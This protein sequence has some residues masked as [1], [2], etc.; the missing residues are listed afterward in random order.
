MKRMISMITGVGPTRRWAHVA[1]P[2]V[3]LV[4]AALFLA[5]QSPTKLASQKAAVRAA[6]DVV[7][8]ADVKSDGMSK[9]EARAA[10]AKLPMSFEPNLGQT[11]PRVK[12]L[13]R[14]SGYMAFLTDDG[15][16]VRL[17]QSESESAVVTM[18]FSGGHQ[19]RSITP[20]QRQEGV[21]NYAVG[22]RSKW[23]SGVPN[24]SRVNYREV[25][26]GVDTVF[27][28]DG[29]R[30]RYDLVVH[31]GADPKQIALTF[32]GAKAMNVDDRGNL[33]LKTGGGDVVYDKPFVY[34]EIAG[35]RRPVEG[36]YRLLDDHQVGFDLG[37]YDPGQ[38]LVI[39]PVL[40]FTNTYVGG[41]NA[42][43]G[44][45]FDIVNGVVVDLSFVYITGATASTDF[46]CT[47]AA[48]ACASAAPGVSGPFGPKLAV[49]NTDAFVLVLPRA[50]GSGVKKYFTL[51]G[52]SEVDAGNGI[53]VANPKALIAAPQAVTVVGTSNSTDLPVTTGSGIGT[54]LGGKDAFV[55]QFTGAG[56]VGWAEFVGGP[57]TDSGLGIAFGGGN[58][59]ITGSTTSV[60]FTGAPAGGFQTT[61]Q[62][63]QDAYV[64]ELKGADGTFLAFTYY[65]GA[66]VENGNAIAWDGVNAR[67]VFDGDTTSIEAQ[68]GIPLFVAFPLVP[69]VAGQPE[70]FQDQNNA[71]VKNLATGISTTSSAFLAALTPSLALPVYS[72]FIGGSITSGGVLPISGIPGDTATGVAVDSLGN[73]YLVGN[74]TNTDL[75]FPPPPAPPPY[76][77]FGGGAVV[78]GFTYKLRSSVLA[79]PEVPGGA[80]ACDPTVTVAIVPAL[81]GYGSYTGPPSNAN[82]VAVDSGGQAYIVGEAIASGSGFLER[83]DPTGA[84]LN[85]LS[86]PNG[87]L[88]G[89]V[90]NMDSVA[91]DANR[92]MFVGGSF[93]DVGTLQC[94]LAIGPAGTPSCVPSATAFRTMKPGPGAN[95]NDGIVIGYSFEDIV[96]TPAIPNPIVIAGGGAAVTLPE[97]ATITNA[98]AAPPFTIDGSA[99]P[100]FTGV[101]YGG[102]SSGAACAGWLDASTF[103]A[104]TGAIQLIVDPSKLVAGSTG[105]PCGAAIGLTATFFVSA[106]PL[107]PLAG[108][109]NAPLAVTVILNVGGS[110]IVTPIPITPAPPGGAGVVGQRFFLEGTNFVT[111]D[112]PFGAPASG[113]ALDAVTTDKFNINSTPSSQPYTATIGP[114][115]GADPFPFG[116]GCPVGDPNT[117]AGSWLTW[118][119]S[120]STASAGTNF[121][122]TYNPAVLGMIDLANVNLF[123]GPGG[124][125]TCIAT[126]QIAV[127]GGGTTN[128]VVQVLFTSRL[129]TTPAGTPNPIFPP[130]LGTPGLTYNFPNNSFGQAV[131][132]NIL[133][134][135]DHFPLNFLPIISTQLPVACVFGITISPAFVTAPEFPATTPFNVNVDPTGCPTGN[136]TGVVELFPTFPVQ[137]SPIFVP[138]YVNV[139]NLGVAVPNFV[140]FGN[141]IV[142]DNNCTYTPPT[143]LPVVGTCTPAPPPAQPVNVADI[144]GGGNQFTYSVSVMTA[145]NVLASYPGTPFQAAG[146]E[147][148]WAKATIPAGGTPSSFTLSIN[149]TP[150]GFPGGL[151]GNVPGIYYQG[152]AAITRTG[153][154][155]ISNSPI[156]VAFAFTRYTQ[157]V[158]I[159]GPG[160]NPDGQPDNL[161]PEAPNGTGIGFTFAATQGAGLLTPQTFT[162]ALDGNWFANA[163]PPPATTPVYNPNGSLA[164]PPPFDGNLTID[165]ETDQGPPA[166]PP[167]AQYPGCSYT[168]D[169]PGGVFAGGQPALLPLV[170]PPFFIGGAGPD[171]KCPAGTN[172]WL[173]A[174]FVTPA[175]LIP[176]AA[177]P[178]EPQLYLGPGLGITSDPVTVSADV[179]NLAAGLYPARIRIR[180]GVQRTNLP[181][182]ID[183]LSVANGTAAAD[184]SFQGEMTIPVLLTVTGIN[185]GAVLHSSSP[186]LN[187]AF[188]TGGSEPACQAVTVTATNP[189][190][191]VSLPVNATLTTTPPAQTWLTFNQAGGPTQLAGTTTVQFSVCATATLAPATYNGNLALTS[192]NV[193]TVNVPV[194]FVVNPQPTI[195]VL[196]P[197]PPVT[198][199]T[200]V[201]GAPIPNQTLAVTSTPTGVSSLVASKTGAQCGFLTATLTGTTAPT[202]LTLAAS[203]T[204]LTGAAGGTVYTCTVNLNGSGGSP[205]APAVQ[206]S[207]PVT[208]TVYPQPQ[209]ATNLPSPPGI[210]FGF[211]TGNPTP[212][213]QIANLTV[214]NLDVF[215]G[216][217][218]VASAASTVAAQNYAGT[219][220]QPSGSQTG[221]LQTSPCVPPNTPC[222]VTISLNPAVLGL[223]AAGTYTGT[224]TYT[225]PNAISATTLVTL[226]VTGGAN[227]V[228]A[229][230]TLNFTFTYG[231]PNPANQTDGITTNP[232]PVP[233]AVVVPATPACA[234]LTT[235][236]L[237]SPNS[238]STLTVGVT[239]PTPMPAGLPNT[240]TCI[241]SVVNPPM[242]PANITVNLQLLPQPVIGAVPNPV[243]FL[244]FTGE[245]CPAP[246][247]IAVTVATPLSGGSITITPSAGTIT[248]SGSSFSAAIQPG[249][250]SA[251]ATIVVTVCQGTLAPGPYAGSV[252]ISSPDAADVTVPVN[253]TVLAV[254]I[255]NLSTTGPLVFNYTV[256]GVV[257]IAQD[258]NVT[259]LSPSSGLSIANAP[260]STSPVGAWLTTTPVAATN[261]P[262]TLAAALNPAVLALFTP[263]TAGTYTGTITLS[264]P[265]P[266]GTGGIGATPVQIAV[267]L[268][269]NTAPVVT[270]NPAN[271][272]VT[273]PAAATFTAAAS[274][275]PTPNVQ[276][277][278][279]TDGGLTFSN[280]VGQNSTT[281]TINPTT[282]AMNGNKY[283]AVF[284]N[285][286]GSATTTAATL[287][288]QFPPVVTVN[289]L[290]QTVTA[291]AAATFTAAATGN[292]T[293]AVQW[294]VSTDG[295]VTFN[296]IP[297]ANSTTLVV[298][299][300]SVAMNGNQYQAVFA[301]VAGTATSTA[302]VLTVLPPGAASR[303]ITIAP[304]RLVDTRTANGTFGGPF[305]AGGSTR[306]FPIP[307]QGTCN[308][309]ST[310]TAYVLNLAVV[311]RAGT[312]GFATMYPTGQ[313]QPNVST[314]NSPDGAVVANGAIIPAGTAGSIN[315]FVTNDTDVVLDI[316]AYLVPASTVGAL[317]F[318]AVAPCRAV[319]TRNGA[320]IPAGTSQ[321]FP[322]QGGTCGL[323]A[324]AQ[325]YSLNVTA[326]PRP[327][328]SLGFLTA[329]P[330]GQGVP[331]TSTLNTDTNIRANGT[332]VTAGSPNGSVS[333]FANNDT[334]VVVDINGYFAAP[335]PGTGSDFF[336]VA[337][338]RDVD[339]RFSIN[340]PA[341]PQAGGTDQTYAVASACGLPANATA[342]AFNVTVVPSG[343]LGFLTM[344]PT[345]T[346]QPNASTLNDP[347]GIIL[348]NNAI[349]PAGT[350]GS[351]D[352]FVLQ[353]TQVILDVFGYFKK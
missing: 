265:E 316:D 25:F 259:S 86:F 107:P 290:S 336:T 272:T 236:T 202:T 277:Q 340:S 229:S 206:T 332:I 22:P 34:Q 115:N 208:L 330:T 78:N 137:G 50:G 341:G 227:I 199:V 68:G 183:S 129:I 141:S 311:P 337:P 14:G 268:N 190:G 19:A 180:H 118:T 15:A 320:F 309:P 49:P 296:N 187:F 253:L 305:M 213:P 46:P 345:G 211:T 325:A 132:Q 73:V 36:S 285:I 328:K 262:F 32:G 2:T 52:G 198:F 329:Y 288:V 286:A 94:A 210:S 281:L 163:A 216:Q 321:A 339:T 335:I 63:A 144:G 247:N 3:F 263:A 120:G 270:L 6:A 27:Y 154:S 298:T 105:A 93:N 65:G 186:A 38:T 295:G 160:T 71:P 148:G 1:V 235:A 237:S 39:D 81:C 139:G 231:G 255:I 238:P 98:T 212:L 292:P 161:R 291:P 101:V 252:K 8:S 248:G 197:P 125:P 134:S 300:T 195:Q 289:P 181:L 280:L 162:V 26:P 204:G 254:P 319:D 57:G 326:V 283:R 123:P 111:T 217:L 230:S 140:Q 261:S 37:Q 266:P 170:F 152:V 243:N 256:G 77:V 175:I 225:S 314:L 279:S 244:T 294:Q 258:V 153:G 297:G 91:V 184:G 177:P 7:K 112:G 149:L 334:D 87:G 221:W 96:V 219:P 110:I 276:W 106:G 155:F 250:T 66:G 124:Y 114:V 70:T 12:Y 9:A 241:V 83:V 143:T 145:A 113:N 53:A 308:I 61:L 251:A 176:F 304:C 239:P 80:A 72:T 218:P 350:G 322:L 166:G 293:P 138:I 168:A 185:T 222:T 99:G 284:S 233:L 75:A 130:P 249:A 48:A 246:Q 172:S 242:N 234:F 35:V 167:L 4:L 104:A 169:L 174:K 164:V 282:A 84:F 88:G 159:D 267:T 352:V 260:A 157:P 28:G 67:V 136:L 64:A 13:A 103:V 323:P 54:G 189:G 200:A 47:G 69:A 214:G 348:A 31:K 245:A 209:L 201:N 333:F 95:P 131:N 128:V 171:T 158:A 269:V 193:T 240:L 60:S 312:L 310:A 275:V 165:V 188:T 150:T 318:Y 79:A 278:V 100:A 302:A 224:V 273:A 338:C 178:T 303:L 23:I 30:M 179:S 10:L 97:Q 45:G 194:T 135:G 349:M 220:N 287:T 18:Q 257:P 109:D 271:V 207:F 20:L 92:A 5:T 126:I 327:G 85:F 301:N 264:S 119:H 127:T 17:K 226:T 346:P 142:T 44:T 108:P 42:T 343:V 11:D 344:F 116:K 24:Y 58:Y 29:T 40:N 76:F 89:N 16:V 182:L 205:V 215:P 313:S 51:F 146:S 122:V 203:A 196:P 331:A 173:H 317:Q 62:G 55:A 274:G 56:A 342:Y 307:S 21:T 191:P 59:Y 299:P 74:T 117:G 90:T 156:L 151:P 43:G 347:K 82:A 353:S 41:D 102:P 306:T 351:D 223:L 147:T 232:T 121:T 228:A 324:T 192:T 133:V 33:I 315:V